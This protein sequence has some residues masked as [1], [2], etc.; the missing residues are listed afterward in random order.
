[1]ILYIHTRIKLLNVW[2]L[3]R[4]EIRADNSAT[5]TYTVMEMKRTSSRRVVSGDHRNPKQLSYTKTREIA[6]G[7][8]AFWSSCYNDLSHSR[9]VFPF[10]GSPV[11]GASP[12]GQRPRR[13]SDEQRKAYFPGSALISNFHNRVSGGARA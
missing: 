5:T 13:T 12:I 9:T 10:P 11:E 4:W 8:V 1:M 3:T 2:L 6:Q 7:T